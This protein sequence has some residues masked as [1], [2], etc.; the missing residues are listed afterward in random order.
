MTI[1]TANGTSRGVCR[2]SRRRGPSQSRRAA[3]QTAVSAAS[4]VNP[5]R[6]GAAIVRA[7]MRSTAARAT[8]STMSAASTIRM[9]RATVA[10]SPLTPDQSQPKAPPDRRSRFPTPRP[11]PTSFRSPR[12]CAPGVR[13][14]LPQRQRHRRA[15]RPQA[16]IQRAHHDH[17]I[18]RVSGR[19]SRH[20]W[21][22]ACFSGSIRRHQ[23]TFPAWKENSWGGL[24]GPPFLRY[25]WVRG[26]LNLERREARCRT[27]AS[28][29]E[30]WRRRA[31]PRIRTRGTA[32]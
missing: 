5:A 1:T 10:A 29:W 28:H 21:R 12:T 8:A 15:L 30:E 6:A 22:R 3:A 11:M 18:P 13:F 31:Y 19:E 9:M 16:Q 20:I 14:S 23:A 4:P 2:R 7:A 25:V 17:E 32:E 26:V 27:A 24:S